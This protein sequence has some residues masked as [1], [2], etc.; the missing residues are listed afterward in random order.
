MKN[1]NV[2]AI[3]IATISIFSSCKKNDS[4]CNLI[5]AKIV[6]YDC[7][8]VIF[9]LITT[10]TIGDADW[11][12]VQNGQRYSNVLSCCNTC[13]IA[14]FTKGKKIT[15]YVSFKV[16]DTNPTIPD[17]F[18]CEAIS[19]NPPQTKVDFA[20]ISKSVCENYSNGLK[21][22]LNNQIAKGII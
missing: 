20:E 10:E 12:D 14:E 18:R 4:D 22:L 19:Q 13:K 2:I 7:D 21:Y 6:R 16:Q 5:A 15:L 17:C 3:L 8:R 11:E 9:Q 1:G